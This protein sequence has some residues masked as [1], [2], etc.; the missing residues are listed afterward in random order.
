MHCEDSLALGPKFPVAAMLE[1]PCS[2]A[3][4]VFPSLPLLVSNCVLQLQCSPLPPLFMAHNPK[5]V[6]DCCFCSNA[7]MSTSPGPRVEERYRVLGTDHGYLC[8]QSPASSSQD[9][10]K[11]VVVMRGCA[12]GLSTTEY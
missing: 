3:L 8:K 6:R 1:G 5:P 10:R 2:H 11:G 12:T 7:G 4:T 9:S